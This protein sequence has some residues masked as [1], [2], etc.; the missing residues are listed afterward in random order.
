VRFVTTAIVEFQ[1]HRRFASKTVDV[2]TSGLLIDGDPNANAKPGDDVW[3]SVKLPQERR[4]VR[5]DAVIVRITRIEGKPAWAVRLLDPP[6]RAVV[7]L[8]E[9]VAGTAAFPAEAQPVAFRR[10]RRPK[11][12]E[13]SVGS[14]PHH[15]EETFV[16]VEGADGDKPTEPII[17]PPLPD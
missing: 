6:S 11:P 1:Q 12:R 7:N 17:P 15:G 13:E 2:S 5:L 10:R 9:V 3:V 14:R 4:M 16:E 8:E